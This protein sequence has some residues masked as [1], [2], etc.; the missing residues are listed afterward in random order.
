MLT[1]LLLFYQEFVLVYFAVLNLLYAL[2]GY[3]GLRSVIVYSREL[4]EVAL[5]DLL[6]R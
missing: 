2:F 3:L 4:P 5:K 1:L 6:E